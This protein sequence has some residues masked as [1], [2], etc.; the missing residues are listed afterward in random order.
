MIARV[1]ETQRLTLEPLVAS[2][3]EVMFAGLADERAYTYIDDDRFATVDGLRERYASLESRASPDGTQSWLNWALARKSHD[4]YI[5]Y[6][7]ATIDEPA[8]AVIGYLLFTD[9]WRQG[10]GTEAVGALIAHLFADW[11][12]ASIDA[13][14][15]ERNAASGALLRK[16]GFV[17]EDAER[18]I[19]TDATKNILE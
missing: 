14:A 18:W 12:I 13:F 11:S 16:L 5:G 15:D 7:Q 8:H 2:H 17:R 4:D 10:Y 3:A 19:L 1:L 9:H 6:V